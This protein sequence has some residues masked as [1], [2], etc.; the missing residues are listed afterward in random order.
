[1]PAEFQVSP[2]SKRACECV[3]KLDRAAQECAG[4]VQRDEAY[5]CMHVC[6]QEELCLFGCVSTCP[7][8]WAGGVVSLQML[9][10]CVVAHRCVC[11]GAGTQVRDRVACGGGGDTLMLAGREREVQ[12]CGAQ[13][14]LSSTPLSY[15][16]QPS[17]P[18]RL[19]RVRLVGAH[20][21]EEVLLLLVVA[22]AQQLALLEHEFIPLAQLPLAHAAAET[23]QVVHALQRPHHELGG[24]DLLHAA[25]ALRREEPA[26]HGGGTGW[27]KTVLPGSSPSAT[28]TDSGRQGNPGGHQ[29]PLPDG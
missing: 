28:R 23:A 27:A 15:V 5:T 8:I 20:G 16:L 29:V 25:A 19:T 12:L 18:P 6:D 17:R 2:K 11:L 24:R 10:T 26:G 22:L 4:L 1:M 21:A 9:G 13:K 7:H 3:Y 14:A